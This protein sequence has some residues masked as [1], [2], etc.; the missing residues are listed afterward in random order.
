L[1]THLNT[2]VPHDVQVINGPKGR[3]YVSPVTG[4]KYPSIT[5]MLGAK[6]KPFLKE[7]RN[8]LGDK[9]ADKE[10][11]RAADRGTAVH[12]MIEN[13]LNNKENPTAGYLPEHVREFNQVRLK[14]NKI[15]NIYTQ[16]IPLYSDT[17]K[18]AGRVDCI[19]EYDGALAVIDFKTSNGDKKVSMID[20][21][22]KQTCFYALA[23][24]E[25]YDIQIDDLVIIMSSEK[26]IVPLVFRDK[27]ENWIEPLVDHINTYYKSLE[28]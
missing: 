2:I 23:F 14:L 26:G 8:M 22:W 25:M 5:T 18:I 6:E 11:K 28:K 27:V 17:L 10:M 13:Y 15:N 4:E 12:E 24:Q 3:F 9:K 1:F 7:W 20:S 16:E 19:G 21:Y